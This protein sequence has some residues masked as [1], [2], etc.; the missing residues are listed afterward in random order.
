[1]IVIVVS[2]RKRRIFSQKYDMNFNKNKL[3][4]EKTELLELLVGIISIL[5]KS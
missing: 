1:M 5:I 3:S 2:S 4:I